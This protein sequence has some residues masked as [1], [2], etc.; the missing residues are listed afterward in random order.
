MSLPI[1]PAIGWPVVPNV[2]DEEVPAEALIVPVVARVVPAVALVVEAAC[3]F[4]IR[5][6]E[7]SFYGGTAPRSLSFSPSVMSDSSFN[8]FLYVCSPFANCSL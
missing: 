4:K 2:E 7:F 8:S 5:C 6:S 1:A 3:L